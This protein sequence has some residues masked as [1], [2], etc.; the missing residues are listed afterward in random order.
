MK[1][2]QDIYLLGFYYMKPRHGVRTQVKG[3]MND[4][5][6]ITYDE[7]VEITRGRHKN[8]GNAKVVLN[9]SQKRVEFNGWGTE[10]PFN[11]YFKH[12]FKGFHQYI[13]TVMMQ[14]DAEYL[15]KML[16]EMQLELDAETP[17][18]PASTEL[19]NE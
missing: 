12:Y 1:T 14:L 15:N 5:N 2:Q 4:L 9:L 6:N 10:R 11:D 13:T 8:I 18:E 17:K 3:W 7:N 19:V 16:D